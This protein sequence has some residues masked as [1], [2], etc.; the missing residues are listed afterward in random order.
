MLQVENLVK[1]YDTDTVLDEVSATFEE[2]KCYLL[3]GA[4]GA[5]K[6]TLAKCIAGDEGYESGSIQWH[7]SSTNVSDIV[8]LQYQ[9]FNSYPH[10]KV[11]EVIQLFQRLIVNPYDINELYTLLNVSSFEQTLIKNLSGGQ[12]KTLSIILAFLLNKKIIILD[13]PFATLDLQRKQVLAE[14][15]KNQIHQDRLFIIISHEIAGFEDLFDSILIL[16]NG[17]IMEQG[18]MSDLKKK[19]KQTTF[20]GIEGIYFEVT[21]QVLGG[22]KK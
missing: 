11:R 18:T 9:F 10:L 8:A 17:K 5:G 6:S 13:E 7:N 3:L 14:F 4:N 15:I 19:Y 16:Q 22:Y 12:Q 1:K 21:G 2:G 20:P